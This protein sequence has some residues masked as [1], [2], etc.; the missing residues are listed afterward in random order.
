M[1]VNYLC[2]C[3]S[4]AFPAT[5]PCCGF[6]RR[7]SRVNLVRFRS[8]LVQVRTQRSEQLYQ[9]ALQHIAGGVNSP[10]RSFDAVGGK[11]PIFMR[12]AQGAYFWDVDGNKYIDYLAAYGAIILGHAHPAVTEAIAKAAERGT[13]FGTPHEQEI[14]FVEQIK[15]A[16]PYLEKIRLVNSG[17]EAVMSAVRLARG[18]TRRNKIIKFAGCY[19]GHSDPMLLEAGSGPSQLNN[20]VSAGITP[21][22]AQDVIVLPYNDPAALEQFLDELERRGGSGPDGD[23]DIAALLLEPIVGN[24]G[25]VEPRPGFLEAVHAAAAKLGALVIYDEVIT[26]FRFR[27]G[28]AADALGFQPDITVLGKIIGGGLPIGAYGASAEIMDYVSPVGPV[29]QSGTFSGNPVS[30]AAGL[31]CLQTL[32]EPGLYERLERFGK[33]L[34]DGLRESA[35]RHGVAVQVNQRGGGVSIAFTEEPVYDVAAVDR[36]DKAMFAR[37]FRRMLASGIN[38]APSVYEV[39]YVTAAH[40]EQDIEFTLNAIERVFATLHDGDD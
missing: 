30:V 6:R 27:Y 29:Y 17:T 28:S 8:V 23:H 34:A 32:Q 18:V 2:M 5:R 35:A 15:K 14:A 39:L 31:A 40:T 4:R 36:S 33:A 38:L 16:I 25:L 13:V 3:P 20:A 21:G 26:A 12:R 1:E 24:F 11:H 37:F 19:H 22:V 10:A 7:R 9:R